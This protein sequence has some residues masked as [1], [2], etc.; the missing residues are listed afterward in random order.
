MNLVRFRIVD[1]GFASQA[2]DSVEVLS[3]MSSSGTPLGLR[4]LE[5]DKRNH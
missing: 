2:S 1:T 3:S 5:R 4:D